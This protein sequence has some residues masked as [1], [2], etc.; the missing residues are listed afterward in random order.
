MVGGDDY[1]GVVDGTSVNDDA[2]MAMIMLMVVYFLISL[3][4]QTA[5]SIHRTSTK[6]DRE[7][8]E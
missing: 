2:E 4:A 1:D 7:D 3:S 5:L 8:A 6:N